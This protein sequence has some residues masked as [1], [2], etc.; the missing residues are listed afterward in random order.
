VRKLLAIA[1]ML[2]SASFGASGSILAQ[3]AAG[4]MSGEV[5][6]AGGRAISN[7]RV[8]LLQAGEVSQTTITGSRGEYIF[9][10][11]AAGEYVVRV[12]VNGQVAGIRVSIVPGQA[13]ANGLIVAPSAAAP[14][15]AFLAGLG[16]LGG[17]IATAA[18]ITA[19]VITV[20]VVTGS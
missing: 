16:L 18:I 20:V 13:V 8:D 6:D 10:N 2:A 7:Q 15:A 1:L 3:A 11:V 14:S 19:V 9:S 4:S 17:V 5:V 12:V